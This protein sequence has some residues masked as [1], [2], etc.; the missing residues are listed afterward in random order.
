[1]TASGWG[2]VDPSQGSTNS[3]RASWKMGEIPGFP[4]LKMVIF[5]LN[6][7]IFQPAMLVYQAEFI[8][9]R[10]FPMQPGPFSKNFSR[11]TWASGRQNSG[12]SAQSDVSLFFGL[13]VISMA[14]FFKSWPREFGPIFVTDLQGL[15]DLHFIYQKVTWKK[16]GELF[17]V[18]DHFRMDSET[19][20][21]LSGL[22]PP[23]KN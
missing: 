7:V 4:G 3:S 17:V 6:M 23:K 8:R 14:R 11:A 18:V 10:I 2:P 19:R 9:I 1:M 15:S 22:L 5:L 16:L 12:R 20:S 21:R 13:Q